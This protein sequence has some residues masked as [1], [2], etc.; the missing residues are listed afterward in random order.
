[1]KIFR[2]FKRLFRKKRIEK[3]E[4]YVLFDPSEFMWCG[5]A[6]CQGLSSRTQDVHSLLKSDNPKAK[7]PLKGGYT[8]GESFFTKIIKQFE[9]E[10]N[11]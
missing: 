6:S 3:E 8:V 4:E 5:C 11:R 2:G 7:R 9:Q 1:M 10:E